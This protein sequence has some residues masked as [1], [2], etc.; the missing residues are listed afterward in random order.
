MTAAPHTDIRSVTASWRI[1]EQTLCRACH[2]VLFSFH[3][4]VARRLSFCVC[5]VKGNFHPCMQAG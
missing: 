5:P 2:P 4:E 1:N 3:I